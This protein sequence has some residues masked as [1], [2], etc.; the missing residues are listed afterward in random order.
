M[1]DQEN[2]DKTSETNES[3][4]ELDGIASEDDDSIVEEAEEEKPKPKIERSEIAQKKK[5]RERAE[6]TQQEVDSLKAE[7]AKLKT[8][9]QPTEDEE[10]ELRAKK[11]IRDAALEAIEEREKQKSKEKNEQVQKFQSQLDEAVEEYADLTEE[12]II[13]T[14]E[15]YEVEPLIAA[16]IL[17]KQGATKKKTGLPSAKKGSPNISNK[18]DDSK[19]TIWQI[20]QE[21]KNNL[22]SKQ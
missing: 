13:A 21:I 2:D 12:Q 15:E 17:S 11:Y 22:K 4:T 19:K 3:V 8:Q 14:C 18:P 7:I 20:A 6:R 10:K 5:W 16:K 1:L 9:G